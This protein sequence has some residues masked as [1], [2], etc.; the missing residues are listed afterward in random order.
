M[1]HRNRLID[2]RGPLEILDKSPGNWVYHLSTIGACSFAQ[3]CHID[4]TPLE[5]IVSPEQWSFR[6]ELKPFIDTMQSSF[7]SL[8][9][10]P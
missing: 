5:S 7:M 8:R 10:V 6:P 3:Y 2:P 1:A 9:L 4:S